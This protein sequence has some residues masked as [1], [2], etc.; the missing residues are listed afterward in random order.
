MNA[1]ITTLDLETLIEARD[2]ASLREKIKNWPAG[3]LEHPWDQFVGGLGAIARAV[4]RN[5]SSRANLFLF[6]H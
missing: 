5:G 1:A 2:F 6:T 4:Q 3:D